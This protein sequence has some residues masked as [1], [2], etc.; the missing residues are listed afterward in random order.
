M[1]YKANI[2]N[3]HSDKITYVVQER[4]GIEDGCYGTY[5]IKNN[6]FI[7]NKRGSAIFIS[8]IVIQIDT[9]ERFLDLFFYDSHGRKVEI[10]LFPRKNLTELGILE[11]LNFGAQ[12]IK[13]DTKVLIISIQNQEVEAPCV[14]TYKKLGFSVYNRK[15]IFMG[16]K[17]I[18]VDA[19]Y[20]GKLCIGRKG[21][22]KIIKNMLEQEVLGQ[23][24]LEFILAVSGCGVLTDYLRDTVQVD[25]PIISIVGESSSG[26][27]TAGL[28]AVA[29]GAKPS[30]EGDSMVLTFGDT[31]NAIM[32]S[33][34]SSF[35]V[36]IDEGSLCRGNQTSLLYNLAIG[37][38]RKR[39]TKELEKA[40]SSY[41]STV[42]II[43]S[44]KSLL[45]MADENTGLLVRVLE[46]QNVVWT[47]SSQSADTIKNICS[48][49]YGYIVYKMAKC[50]LDIDKDKKQESIVS[51]YWKWQKYLVQ[52]AKA[53]GFYNNLTERACKQYALIM[54]SAS[55][56]QEEMG[57]KLHMDEIVNFI[58][59]H[60]PV[61]ESS[62]VDIG[63]RA[64]NYLL[65]Y[66]TR[67]YTQIITP[68]D[69]DFVP[70]ICLG[71]VKKG[72]EICLK[73]GSISDERLYISDINLQKILQEGLFPDKKVILKRW[74]EI[75]YL[76]SE[77]DRYLSNVSIIKGKVVSGYIIC[78]LRKE[79]TDEIENNNYH[80]RGEIDDSI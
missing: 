41:F 37:R 28:L 66:I 60:S 44:E 53:K 68:K 76:Q 46:I 65:Q 63:E 43:T 15:K 58:Q 35:P 34:E 21:D 45:G 11:L 48:T 17:A 79:N 4:I 75:G 20:N 69:G 8:R 67:F 56:I 18:G 52:D 47:K 31:N 40:E 27:S 19:K 10:P 55:L 29:A 30:F 36:L 80:D 61:K 25:N 51:R 38:E 50:I 42:I 7:F 2:S 62:I 33:I 32:S 9:G 26:K 70:P 12:I 23:I 49:N 16:R 13:Q 59:E 5:D 22:F 1:N 64:Y 39:L 14:L 24:P 57:I 73:N 77:K 54:L 78:L 71:R 72:K 74:K 6:T 3:P